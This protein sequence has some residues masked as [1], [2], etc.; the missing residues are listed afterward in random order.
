MVE[1]TL[2]PG[3]VAVTDTISTFADDVLK[4]SAVFKI[5]NPCSVESNCD[6]VMPIMTDVKL[7]TT[8]D[9]DELEELEELE[10]IE[11]DEELE[12]LELELETVGYITIPLYVNVLT[13]SVVNKS[14][15]NNSINA[16][17]S[18]GSPLGVSKC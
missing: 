8:W 12:E 1:L 10:D 3:A 15:V 5:Y 2:I 13:S 18:G 7:T 9:E 14:V 16:L 17:S 11:L 6:T 4:T